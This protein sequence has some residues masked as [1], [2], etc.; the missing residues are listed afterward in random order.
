MASH[1][2]QT[3][4]LD[5][6]DELDVDNIVSNL[7][8]QMVVDASETAVELNPDLQIIRAPE[9][10]SE[11]VTRRARAVADQAFKRYD[12]DGSGTIEKHEL[13]DM[14]LTV[15]QV[16]PAGAN[17]A[18]KLEYLE[19]QWAIADTDGNGTVDFDEFVEFYVCTLEALAAEEAA[20]HAFSRYACHAHCPP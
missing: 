15:G 9:F 17:D 18:A 2:I 5:V 7:A 1:S 6:A 19:T 10:D 12:A 3:K 4:S 20:R 11:E 14:C 13:F 8:K 16:A